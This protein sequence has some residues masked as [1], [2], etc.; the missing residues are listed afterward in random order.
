MKIAIKKM[1]YG[2]G[3]LGLL[4]PACDGSPDSRAA[5]YPPHLVN[6]VY[7]GEDSEGAW[8]T[9]AF[10][11]EDTVYYFPDNAGC[12]DGTYAY[13]DGSGRITDLSPSQQMKLKSDPLEIVP[14]AF[15]ISADGKTITFAAYLSRGERSFQRVR[16]ADDVDE[17]VPFTY[18]PLGEGDSLDG[19]V[20][21]ATA[22][23]TKD[24][25]T[26]TVTAS[27]TASGT[28][29][30]SHSFDCTSYPRN[31]AKYEYDTE[32]DLDYI[33]PFRINGD[34]FTFLDF[35]GHG[36]VITLKRMR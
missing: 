8:A 15:A 29:Q 4:L 31:Y 1:V 21:A 35:Y 33:G 32:T 3:C 27:R 14:G 18:T 23:R 30:V 36:G 17:E 24:W 20:W 5:A 11:D 34:N 19:T 16:D 25:T 28:I 2:L 7:A 26:L 9:F 10:M 13:A 12:Y 22:Y 6:T